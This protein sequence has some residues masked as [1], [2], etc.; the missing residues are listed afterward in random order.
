MVRAA[1]R[2][3]RSDDAFAG[4]N[5]GCVFAVISCAAHNVHTAPRFGVRSV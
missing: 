5:S 1:S 4:P 2:R 3:W